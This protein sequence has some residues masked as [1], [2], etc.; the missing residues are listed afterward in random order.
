MAER[1]PRA[2]LVAEATHADLLRPDLVAG[3]QTA[4][5]HLGRAAIG[6]VLEVALRPGG[7]R[8]SLRRSPRRQTAAAG[9]ARD[10]DQRG[11]RTTVACSGIWPRRA[12][13]VL[14]AWTSALA[15]PVRNSS[16]LV[17]CPTS[18]NAV[19][20]NGTPSDATGFAPALSSKCRCAP[21]DWPVLPTRASRSPRRTC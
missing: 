16:M 17:T 4:D 10:G 1:H 6:D 13:G 11:K 21:P 7:H 15:A 3:E 12:E 8:W 18:E 5:R 9:V 20:S 14:S 19:N 2:G